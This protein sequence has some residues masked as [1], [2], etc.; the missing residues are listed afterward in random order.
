MN[1]MD[2]TGAGTALSRGGA[3]SVA[4]TQVARE[5]EGGYPA[6]RIRASRSSVTAR[7]L[8]LSRLALQPGSHQEQDPVVLILE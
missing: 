7:A 6:S 3:V 5:R 1:G 8:L 2:A 4:E